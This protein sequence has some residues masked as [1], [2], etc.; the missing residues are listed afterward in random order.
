MKTL[1]GCKESCAVQLQTTCW[2]PSG[3][4]TLNNTG[5]ED[6]SFEQKPRHCFCSWGWYIPFP[7]F[8]CN[9]RQPLTPQWLLTKSSFPCCLTSQQLCPM[10]LH[11]GLQAEDV[12]AVWIMQLSGRGRSK[13]RTTTS[14]WMWHMSLALTKSSHT[15]LGTR[16][17]PWTGKYRRLQSLSK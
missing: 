4:P 15:V 12:A 5:R 17:G 7:R 8:C 13:D 2:G 10:C 16:H 1:V 11:S 6:I 9:A 3:W 14:V